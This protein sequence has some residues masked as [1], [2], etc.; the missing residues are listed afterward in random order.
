M[1]ETEP[2]P[3]EA[4][5]GSILPAN[6]GAAA[7]P[8]SVDGALR[9][10]FSFDVPR[11]PKLD[12]F[13]T[14]SHQAMLNAALIAAIGLIVVAW[15]YGR[16]FGDSATLPQAAP[17]EQT[18]AAANIAANLE[19]A[20]NP[21]SDAPQVHAEAYVDPSATVV[22]HVTIAESAYVAATV[23][24]DSAAGQP[25]SI[26]SGAVLEAGAS[27]GARGTFVRSR[28]DPTAFVSAGGGEW[29]V[30]I[31]AGATVGAGSVVRGPVAILQGA[32]VGQGA[33]IVESTIGAGAVVEPGAVVVGVTVA[34]GRYVPAG[35]TVADQATADALPAIASG[36]RWKEAASESSAMYVALLKAMGHSGA[37]ADAAEETSAGEEPVVAP[38]DEE[39][40]EPTGD[41]SGHE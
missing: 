22:G 1:S 18:A 30:Y 19:S 20:Y 36:Y 9:F 32:Y 5:G 39:H 41:D 4:E 8:R 23:S 17:V 40:T 24:I 27:I 12:S 14:W 37:L 2:V 7:M 13:G 28:T 15:A 10:S 33:T 38:G 21:M 6:D 3:S 25:I 29:A 31:G 34:N 11:L 26:G 35:A 16:L